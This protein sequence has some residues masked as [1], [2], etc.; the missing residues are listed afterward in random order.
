MNIYLVILLSIPLIA[1]LI[2]PL[3]SQRKKN[4][5]QLVVCF[6]CL[7]SVAAL[8]KVTVGGDLERYLPEYYEIMH[9][10]WEDVV[11]EGY[12]KREWGYVLFVKLISV[13]WPTDRGYLFFTSFAFL[14]LVFTSIKKHSKIVWLS[15]FVFIGYG[16]F[17]NSL[18]IIRASLSISIGLYSYTYI[19]SRS[20]RNFLIC[21]V[22]A[23]LI[24]RTAIFVFSFYFIWSMRYSVKRVLFIISTAFVSSFLLTG[25]AFV[26]IVNKYIDI[27][28]TSVEYEY[29]MAEG[30]GYINLL[31]IFLF[32]FTMFGMYVHSKTNVK[33]KEF[34]F[35]LYMLAIAT[36][37]QM[38]SSVFTLLNRISVLFGCFIIY[39]V[40]LLVEKNSNK[41]KL[42]IVPFIVLLFVVFF[43]RLMRMDPILGTDT[44]GVTPY[45]FYWE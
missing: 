18:N 9:S 22:C 8:R 10:N 6:G 31:S 29:N 21:A 7:L 5:I 44:Q 27:Y 11:F 15:L 35:F 32:I 28:S 45:L 36:S 41:S 16:L 19:K 13:F 23:F 17:T 34:E 2:C 25:N 40:P 30:S 14:L 42:L 38:F 26:V 4:A 1:F 12:G 37:I 33:D 43:C 20:F 24:H 3:T 39:Y